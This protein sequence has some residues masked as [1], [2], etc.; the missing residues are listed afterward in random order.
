MWVG[1]I[2]ISTGVGGSGMMHLQQFGL[3]WLEILQELVGAGFI[4]H[5]FLFLFWVITIYNNITIWANKSP[6]SHQK[7][8]QKQ[9]EKLKESWQCDMWSFF[10]CTAAVLW[11]KAMWHQIQASRRQRAT[12]YRQQ[13]TRA[14]TH[15]YACIHA[16]ANVSLLAWEWTHTNK[17]TQVKKITCERVYVT[18]ASCSSQSLTL[19]QWLKASDVW[20]WDEQH[21][22]WIGHSIECMCV[23]VLA[24]VCLEYSGI[25]APFDLLLQITLYYIWLCRL[26]MCVREK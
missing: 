23:Y 20:K 13:H 15:N 22:E 21:N 3:W 4:K 19:F 9:V 12:A 11:V 7:V 1:V 5:R 8:S 16:L 6:L 17:Y 2:R 25:S 10:L 18:Y 26:C 24:C 14:C